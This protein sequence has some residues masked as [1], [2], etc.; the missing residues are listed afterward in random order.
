MFKSEKSNQHTK[1]GVEVAFRHLGHVI[2]VEKL[3]LISL[4]AESSQP[5][6]THHRL[7]P[8]DVAKGAHC[9]CK[10]KENKRQVS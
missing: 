3:A 9:T 6:L 10:W 4:F 1:L 7:L 5:V 2:F 8:A